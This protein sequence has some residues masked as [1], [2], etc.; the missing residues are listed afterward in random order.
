MRC[1]RVLRKDGSLWLDCGDPWSSVPSGH[2][3]AGVE[4]QA[5]GG[6]CSRRNTMNNETDFADRTLTHLSELL[7]RWQATLR[8]IE[9]RLRV[10]EI[11]LGTQVIQEAQE[12]HNEPL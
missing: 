4:S 7:L 9:A 1:T 5:H 12:K 11:R 3:G 8:D 10:L 6:D 2:N